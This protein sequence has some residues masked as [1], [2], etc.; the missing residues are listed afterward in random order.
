MNPEILNCAEVGECVLGGTSIEKVQLSVKVQSPL[1][2]LPMLHQVRRK[3]AAKGFTL[4][5]TLIMM[6]LLTILALGLLGLATIELR[7]QGQGEAR[8]VA[9]ANARVG[10]MMALGQLQTSLG[11]DRRISSDASVLAGTKNPSAVGVWTGWSPDLATTSNSPSTPRIDYRTPKSQ[12]GFRGWLVSDP[13]PVKVQQLAWHTSNPS[14]TEQ[15]GLFTLAGSGFDLSATKVPVTTKGSK[16]TFAWAVSQENTKARINIGTDDNKRLTLEDRTQTPSRPDLSLSTLMKQPKSEWSSRPAKI[17]SLSQATLDPEYG[18]ARDRMGQATR[19]FTVDSYSLLTDPVKGGLKVDLT[20]GFE[21]PDTDFAKATWPDRAGSTSNPFRSTTPREYLGQKPLYLPLVNNAQAQVFMNFNPAS[22]NHKFQVNG[23]PTF[24][25][26]RSHYRIHRNL[27]E[28]S[29]ATTAFERP[30]GHIATPETVAGRPFGV[31]TQPSLAPVLDRMNLFFSIYAKA[32]GTLGI[33]MS[34]FVTVWNPYNIDVETEGLVVYPWIDFAVFWNW[35][36]TQAE[37]GTTQTW[38]TS[39]SRFVGEGYE[40]HGRSSRP[41]F[42]L[43]LTQ[44]ANGRVN[45]PIRLAPGEVRVFCLADNTRRDLEVLGSAQTRT[46]QMKPVAGPS[47]ITAS[48][49]GGIVLDMTKSIGGTSNFNYKL[50]TGDRVNAN[51]VSFDRGTYYYIVNMADSYQIRNPG[52]E[53]MVEDRP[54]SGGFPTL[55]A[56]RNLY[57]YDQIH[58]GVSYGKARD[59]FSYPSFTFD[60]IN[61]TPK[62]V[63]SLLTYHRVAQ[64]STLPLS[65]LM[66]TTNPRQPAVNAYLSGAQFQTGPHYETVFQ[67][68]TSLA[69]LAME[70]TF[71]GE[72]AFYGPSQSAATGRSNLA[73]FEVPRTPTLSL[74]ALQHCDIT[75]TPFTCASQIGNSWASPYLSASSVSKLVTST[76]SGEA[77]SPGGL[78]VYDYSY[79]AN[80]ALFDRYYF[81]GAAPVFGAR[82][83]NTGS[84][85]VWEADQISEQKSM[86]EVLTG[87]FQDPAANPLRNPRMI[88]YLGSSSPGQVAARLEGPSRCVR[89]ASNLLVE[90]GFNINS[91]SIEAWTAVLASLRGIE[92]AS[93]DKTAQAR[94][95]HILTGAPASMA[96]ND[97]WS[98]FRTLTDTELRQL[99][100]NIVAEIKTRGP[101][102]SLG[103]FVNRR[104]TALDPTSAAGAIQAAID[105]TPLNRKATYGAITTSAYPNPENISTA[106]TG[107]NTPGWLSQADVLT[108]LAPYLT[109]RSDTFIIRSMGE[110][111]DSSGKILA[112]VRLEAVVQRVPDWVDPA[113]D[114]ATVIASL[115]APINR[116]FGRRFKLVSVKELPA[117]AVL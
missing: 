63:G 3:A 94:F 107:T 116:S 53:L 9:R 90:G 66:F 43:H 110:A 105:K 23:V 40:G 59:S 18:V 84:P 26:L 54:G 86:S 32:D 28:S 115:T 106:N 65:D 31:K 103:E 30:Y 68:G 36:V 24:D 58:S 72:K 99:A 108:G 44:S 79:L 6:V 70:T 56:E 81:S 69:Q 33:L 117:A 49:R 75:A 51:T 14:T 48:T 19:D 93:G 78:G 91:T 60:E 73:F 82:R 29:G 5:V 87:F 52:V 8:A 67:G 62:M 1:G 27:Y 83:T 77:I 89:L 97:P 37:S 4:V 71:T 41:Y 13:D 85:A 21:M 38:N 76:P 15:A 96:E 92:P 55:P 7:S 114:S 34:P 20:T 10:L 101:F 98:G 16:G 113:D 2:A 61:E 102:L 112:R 100:T 17:S 64:S 104:I 22:V 80:E 11:D 25:L 47:D 111:R 95:R 57:F 42:Y 39:L 46:W 45:P 12:T 35:S 88:P 50:K 109:A 74:G